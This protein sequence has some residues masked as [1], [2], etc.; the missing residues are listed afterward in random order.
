MR[1]ATSKTDVPCDCNWLQEHVDDGRWPIVFDSVVNEY[2]FTF[3][4]PH[5]A[6]TAIIR[7]CPW[8]GG[9]APPSKRGT[10]FAR[11]PPE[12]QQRLKLL[13]GPLTSIDDV[14]RVLGTPDHDAPAGT[15]A[16]RPAT[17]TRGRG[18]EHYRSLIYM[19]LSNTAI[20]RVH[21][22]PGGAVGITYSGKYIGP[23]DDS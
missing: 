17:E 9:R 21:V 13:I 7:H 5:G 14:L 10:L 2:H 12:E 3:P 19:N 18:Y 20:I 1:M 15:T 11:I 8:C 4:T 16:I 22:L 6:A 23:R